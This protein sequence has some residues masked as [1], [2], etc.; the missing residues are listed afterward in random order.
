MND[1]FLYSGMTSP[2]QRKINLDKKKR[3]EQRQG[4]RRQLKPVG[5]QLLARIDQ[6]IESTP[7][8]IFDLVSVDTDAET[9]KATVLALKMHDQFLTGFRLDVNNILGEEEDHDI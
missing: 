4:A 2:A 5:K 8:R 6:E 3:E 7:T 1:G 9:Y